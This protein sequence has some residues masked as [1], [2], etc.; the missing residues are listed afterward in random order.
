[1]DRAGLLGEY[2]HSRN[3]MKNIE[4]GRRTLS[5][6]SSVRGDEISI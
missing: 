4:V 3:L 6:S 1:M 5:E 2:H